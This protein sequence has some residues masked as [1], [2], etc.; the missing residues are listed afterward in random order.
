MAL[1]KTTQGIRKPSGMVRALAQAGPGVYTKTLPGGHISLSTHTRRGSGS[2]SSHPFKLIGFLTTGPSAAHLYVRPGMVN[3]YVPTIDMSGTPTSLAAA[4][5][6]YL[7]VTGTSGIVQLKATVDAAGAITTLIAEAVAGPAVTTD[8]STLKYK[9]VGSWTAS[10]G[11]F[12]SVTPILNTN[13][14]LYI[15]GGTAIW[16]A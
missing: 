3:N 15:C 8:T 4:T 16:E 5:P 9:L 1:V 7:T 11:V 13:Q 14:T 10:G 12:T 6:P 2:G